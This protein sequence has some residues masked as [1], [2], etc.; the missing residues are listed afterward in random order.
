MTLIPTYS[1]RTH[2]FDELYPIMLQVSR[3]VSSSKKRAEKLNRPSH[4]LFEGNFM[5][6]HSIIGEYDF[7]IEND[8]II[9][10]LHSEYYP[11]SSPLD[12]EDLLNSA[13]TV[14]SFDR[15]EIGDFAERFGDICQRGPVHLI[16]GIRSFKPGF[17]KEMI[18]HYLCLK[19]AC[20]L[21]DTSE[22]DSYYQQFGFQETGITNHSGNNL[23]IWSR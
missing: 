11:P 15:D 14:K 5:E 3:Q 10:V 19:S 6:E 21:I 1:T 8:K 13:L 4:S 16:Q 7:Y 9:G 17:G 2:S 18:E 20:L 12:F 22:K 23:L